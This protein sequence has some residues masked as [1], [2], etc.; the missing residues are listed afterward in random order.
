[1][2][3]NIVSACK[4]AASAR[5]L[6]LLAAL[7][8]TV[9]GSILGFFGTR[10]ALE[11]HLPHGPLLLALALA[12][13]VAKAVFAL[14]PAA[15]KI[16]ARIRARGDGRCIGAFFSWRAWVF[17]AIISVVG[18][19]I[20]GNVPPHTLGRSIL[21]LVYAWVGIALLLGAVRLWRAWARFNAQPSRA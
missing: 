2:P 20:R 8:W 16:V 4:P 14:F 6:A 17:V 3:A 15:D 11:G 7:T 19:V 18:R 13:G 10:W 12:A 1:M 5:T 21:G 9:I